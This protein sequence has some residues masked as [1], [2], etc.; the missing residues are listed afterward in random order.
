MLGER[1][2]RVVVEAPGVDPVGMLRDHIFKEDNVL[3][4]MGDNVMT[5]A[6]QTLLCGRFGEVGCRAFEGKQREE[7][8]AIAD[9]LE[10]RW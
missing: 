7:L 3:F 10:A 5:E 4:N 2:R 1:E 8:T 9:E 6:D